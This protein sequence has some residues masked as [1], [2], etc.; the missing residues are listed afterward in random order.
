MAAV[1]KAFN[2]TSPSR[3]RQAR[4]HRKGAGERAAGQQGRAREMT[5]EKWAPVFRKDHAQN[6]K[7]DEMT[8]EE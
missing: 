8:F 2:D 5:P 3:H 6:K 1:H 4:G 7:V